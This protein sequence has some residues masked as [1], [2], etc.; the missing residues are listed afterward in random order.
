MLNKTNDL[1]H[2]LPYDLPLRH[3]VIRISHSSTALAS[4]LSLLFSLASVVRS[5]SSSVGYLKTIPPALLIPASTASLRDPY[6]LKVQLNKILFPFHT[7]FF[8]NI[9]STSLG[10]GT[11]ESK[12]GVKS[13]IVLNRAFLALSSLLCLL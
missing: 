13:F 12:D 7:F 1:L 9:R 2:T 4:F 8:T 5:S 6:R 11:F 10:K 3:L